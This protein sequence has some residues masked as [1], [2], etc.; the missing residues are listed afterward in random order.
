MNEIP[1]DLLDKIDEAS[2][3]QRLASEATLWIEEH[4]DQIAYITPENG[5]WRIDLILGP[6]AEA[7]TLIECVQAARK[8]VEAARLKA[9]DR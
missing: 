9:E 6:V 3:R 4:A 7:D 2:K 8:I 5:S 1:G